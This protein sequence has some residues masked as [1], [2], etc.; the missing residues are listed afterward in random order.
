[1]TPQYLFVYG[2]L[3]RHCLNHPLLTDCVYVADAHM[4][5]ELYEVNNYPAAIASESGLIAGELYCL[6]HPE[7]LLPIL[8]DYEECAAHCP[9]PHEYLRCQ[10]TV[11]LTDQKYLAAWVYIYNRPTESLQRIWSGDYL[12]YLQENL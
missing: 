1:M 10:Q 9:E 8:D 12:Q 5:G 7:Q 6:E 4:R 3:R 11:T 2:T